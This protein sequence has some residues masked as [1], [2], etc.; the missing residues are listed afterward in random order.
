MVVRVPLAFV[1]EEPV[2]ALLQWIA[3]RIRWTQTPFADGSRGVA[4]LLQERSDRD[5][6][7]R[8]RFVAL[9]LNLA[10]VANRG[11]ARMFPGHEHATRRRANRVSGIMLGEAHP[12]ASHPVEIG[13]ENLLLA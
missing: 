7:G 5:R 9:G 11:M 4:T 3:F 12:F 6:A 1:A 13:R 2:K 8:E 10:V